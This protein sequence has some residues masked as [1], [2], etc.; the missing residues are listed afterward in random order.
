[1]DSLDPLALP[2]N[3]KAQDV[4]ERLELIDVVLEGLFREHGH[5]DRD[6]HEL[7]VLAEFAYFMGQAFITDQ[8]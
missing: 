2:Y 4:V 1:M 6:N 7:A 3:D 8:M 5:A